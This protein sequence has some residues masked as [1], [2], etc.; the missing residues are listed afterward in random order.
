MCLRRGIYRGLTW[1]L[2][3]SLLLPLVGCGS[4]RFSGALN[5]SGV[6]AASGTVSIVQFTAILD[7]NGSLIDVTI[8]TLSTS[9][10][11]NVLTFCGN[12]ASRFTIGSD[13]QVSFTATQSCSN[14][15]A[16]VLH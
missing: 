12:Q 8:V 13:V 7:G 4:I 16:V 6:L 14:L 3:V 11:T 2:L 1:L 10:G 5:S 15:I 9:P